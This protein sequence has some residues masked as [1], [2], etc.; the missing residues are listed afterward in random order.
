MSRPLK[1]LY[2]GPFP[3]RPG[4]AANSSAQILGTI[5]EDGHQVTVLSDITPEGLPETR[6]PR[7]GAAIEV[8][9]YEVPYFFFLH[10]TFPYDEVHQAAE[11]RGVGRFLP[12]LIARNRPDLIM[13]G[14]EAKVWH[15]ADVANERSIPYI[16]CTRGSPTWQI[17]EGVY[18][19]DLT[20]AWID[21]YRKA[22]LIIPVSTSSADG[23]RRLGLQNVH[24]ISNVV[25][26]DRFAPRPKDEALRKQLKIPEEAT[27]VAFVGVV[28]ERKRPL[29][30]VASAAETI[31]QDPSLI[32]LIV[33]D[34]HLR[35]EMMRECEQRGIAAH[36]RFPGWAEYETIPTYI[37][38]ADLV[39]LPSQGEGL[40]RVYL[41]TQACGRVILASDIAPAREVITPGETGFLFPVGDVAELT[42]Q[43]LRIAR[44]P[45]LRREVGNKAR[46]RSSQHS[47][48][49]IA[50]AYVAA[51][52]DL[53]D[54]TSPGS[55]TTPP[56]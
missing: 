40:A 17:V 18:P 39:V 43:T 13:T 53:L 32:Y 1:I 35:D 8:H 49:R 25:D 11:I 2:L 3:P 24:P 26:T 48:P 55:S 41:E 5:V 10:H 33:G 31:R 51:M 16:L 4:G 42:A 54:R 45:A 46:E 22:D 9:W 15:V 30:I 50:A 6:R 44:D 29:D 27:V 12:K 56:R 36:F 37:N 47:R 34:G 7:D 38:L 14:H 28:Q 21:E 19:E 23:L 52:N 20:Q